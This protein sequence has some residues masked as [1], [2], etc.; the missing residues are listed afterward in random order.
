MID[1][2]L[3]LLVLPLLVVQWRTSTRAEV[4]RGVG[5]RAAGPDPGPAE[6]VYFTCT[7]EVDSLGILAGLPKTATG[8]TESCRGLR[9]R[10]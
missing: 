1:R 9:E 5:H 6:N 10:P 8:G 4:P 3:P 2:V 7:P